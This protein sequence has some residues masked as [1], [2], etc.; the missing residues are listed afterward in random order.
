MD[1]DAQTERDRE[2]LRAGRGPWRPRR[3]GARTRVVIYYE[4][5]DDPKKN[6]ALKLKRKGLAEVTQ[7]VSDLPPH[8]ILLDPF[9]E[10]A[11]SPEDV[12]FVVTASLAAFDCSWETAEAMLPAARRRMEPR[13][14][15]YLVAANPVNFGKP[16]KL[17]TVEA[18]A[19]ALCIYGRKEQAEAA[20]GVVTWGP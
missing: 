5:N 17:S 8:S 1:R 13:A 9:A 10:K 2:E 14:L 3:G 19:A 6:T 7:H 11:V 4:G 15:P 12:P 20:L 16:T 18:I